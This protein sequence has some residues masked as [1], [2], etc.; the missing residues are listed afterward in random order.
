MTIQI[1]KRYLQV[2]NMST[3]MNI[4][5]GTKLQAHRLHPTCHLRV[6]LQPQAAAGLRRKLSVHPTCQLW[7]N[8]AN[9]P[10]TEVIENQAPRFESPLLPLCIELVD[11]P[12][13]LLKFGE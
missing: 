6:Q 7:Y 3:D 9:H 4:G 11:T 13:P 12:A 2:K 10:E 8:K 1:L 5:K